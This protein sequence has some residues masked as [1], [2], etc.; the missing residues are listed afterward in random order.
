VKPKNDPVL[1]T[2]T[3]SLD[4]IAIAI[5][6]RDKAR[7]LPTGDYAL[8]KL[9]IS[10]QV[11]TKLVY[12]TDGAPRLIQIGNRTIKFKTAAA[13]KLSLKGEISMLVIQALSELGPDGVTPDIENKLR[14]ALKEEKPDNIKH[15]AELAPAWIAKKLV[16]FASQI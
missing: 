3:P 11:P 4:E 14:A 9:G 1:G 5:A 15:D 7:L 13:K 8:H 2:I 16:S 10:P 12:L 6:R